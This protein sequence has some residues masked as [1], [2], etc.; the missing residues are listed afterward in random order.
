MGFVKLPLCP[1]LFPTTEDP[2]N[3]LNKYKVPWPKLQPAL[4]GQ[5]INLKHNQYSPTLAIH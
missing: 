3:R 2:E 4:N 1:N 5:V